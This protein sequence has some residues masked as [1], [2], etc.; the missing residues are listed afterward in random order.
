MAHGCDP[1]AA[2]TITRALVEEL[3]NSLDEYH[4]EWAVRGLLGVKTAAAKSK[5]VEVAAKDESESIRE[6]ARSAR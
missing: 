6:L 2:D 3:D 1:Q 5:L 4:R